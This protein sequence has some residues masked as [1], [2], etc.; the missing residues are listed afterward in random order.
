MDR[1]ST[2]C[3]RKTNKNRPRLDKE[4]TQGNEGKC[5]QVIPALQGPGLGTQHLTAFPTQ[6]M[7]TLRCKV[8]GCQQLLSLGLKKGND[9]PKVSRD[10]YKCLKSR[11]HTTELSHP[12]RILEGGGDRTLITTISYNTNLLQFL[13]FGEKCST[14]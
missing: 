10:F 8:D 14:P 3:I 5:H 1:P 9:S 6:C 4:I 2:S 13:F 12:Q 11:S 7:P